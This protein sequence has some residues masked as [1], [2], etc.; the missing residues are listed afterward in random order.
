MNGIG[1]LGE[2]YGL[3]PE[4]MTGLSQIQGGPSPGPGPAPVINVPEQVIGDAPDDDGSFGFGNPYSDPAVAPAKP[5]PG[6][7]KY[8][9]DSHG[10]AITENT[11][12]GDIAK[13]TGQADA[14][15]ELQGPAQ[16]SFPTVR[17]ATGSPG[18]GG[19]TAGGP[20]YTVPAHWQPG[21]SSVSSQRSMMDPEA[22]DRAATDRDIA[23]GHGMLAADGKLEA[24]KQAGMADAVYAGAHQLVAKQTQDQ[25]QAIEDRKTAYVAE[26]KQKL[27][28]LSAA[29]QKQ[30]DPNGLWAERGTGAR[31]GAALMIGLGQFASMASGRGTNAALQIVNE[32]IDRNIAAQRANIDNAHRNL[33]SAQGL[34]ARNLAAFGDEKQ[35]VLATKAMYLDGVAAMADTQRAKAGITDAEAM[36]HDFIRGIYDRRAAIEDDLAKASA[37]HFAEQS[38]K[39]YVPAQRG[40]GVGEKGKESLYVPTLGGYARDEKSATKLNEKGALRMQIG[41]NM[42]QIHGLME[43]AKGL[44]STTD[45]SRLKQIDEQIQ[46]A[47]D[48]ALTKNTVLEGQGAMSAADR[49]VAAQAKALKGVSVQFTRDSVIARQQE[50]IKKAALGML[51]HHRIEGEGYGVQ[52]GNEQ[53]VQGPNGPQAVRRLQGRNAMP[54]KNTQAVDDLVQQPKGQAQ[55]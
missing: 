8:A 31:V 37:I 32:N 53:Y 55:K 6:Q 19:S 48:D 11:T 16:D 21:T 23:Q 9:L 51:E 33:D 29:T 39:H 40:G 45:Y 27:S 50:N 35:A 3:S 44:S 47:T 52:K 26:Q 5:E 20:S 46:Q 41:E 15:M 42:R 13:R 2:L 4:T 1:R 24:A 38:N 34:Y 36:N 18:I 7:Q 54:S 28:D 17:S 14:P 10:Y 49:D 25:I 30:I 12:P 43:E 22:M